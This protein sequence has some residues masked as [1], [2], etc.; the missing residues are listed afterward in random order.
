M[1]KYIQIMVIALAGLCCVVSATMIT[2][3]GTSVSIDFAEIGA[4]GNS[5]DPTNGIGAVSYSYQIGKYEVTVG[6]GEGHADSEN[7]INV[8]GVNF[9]E[10][11]EFER[12]QTK[13]ITKTVTVTDGRLTIDD[14]DGGK[15]RTRI[16]KVLISKQ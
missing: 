2:H 16:H 3:G 12:G 4:P 14:G 1:R 13:E 15:N 8:E 7:T 6:V 9:C 11:L 5:A 10:K